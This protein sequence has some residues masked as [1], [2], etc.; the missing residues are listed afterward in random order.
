MWFGSFSLD[1]NL[2]IS[3]FTSDK[4]ETEYKFWITQ[5]NS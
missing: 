2:K 5:R 4:L 1:I 3:L